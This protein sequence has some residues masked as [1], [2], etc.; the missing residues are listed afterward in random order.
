MNPLIS[1]GHKHEGS[2]LAVRRAAESDAAVTRLRL[3]QSPLALFKV[4][5][6]EVIHSDNTC[7][8]VSLIVGQRQQGQNLPLGITSES[9]CLDDRPDVGCRV[10]VEISGLLVGER[11]FEKLRGSTSKVGLYIPTR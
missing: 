1:A 4:G 8:R 5:V 11:T 6:A 2:R 9:E 3:E 7:A 10:E